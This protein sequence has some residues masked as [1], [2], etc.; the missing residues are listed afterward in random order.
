MN[1]YLDMDDVVADWLVYAQQVLNMTWDEKI[2]E[3]IPQKDWDRLKEEERFYLNLPLKP[4]AHELFNYCKDL[5]ERTGGKLQFL[6]ALPHDYSVPFA[7][8]DKVWWAHKHFPG[9]P[10]FLGPF[11]HDKYRY[12]KNPD[13]I[14]IDDRHSNCSEW[15]AAGGIAHVYTTWE[16]CHKWFEG[17]LKDGL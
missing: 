3:R 13:D 2:G 7:A 12:V 9:T 14:L 10:V 17:L 11:S 16:E 4:G 5:T 6:S 1:I 8:Q 15:I